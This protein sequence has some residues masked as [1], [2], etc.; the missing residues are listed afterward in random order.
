MTSLFMSLA[1]EER[2]IL[3]RIV[4]QSEND[5]TNPEFPPEAPKFPATP[6]R[7]IVIPDFSKVILKDESFNPTGTH[8]DRMAW[9]IVVTYRDILLAKERGSF[10]GPL[11]QMSLISSGS[12]AVAVQTMLKKYELPA[13]KVL[14]DSK[15]PHEKKKQLEK[16]GCEVYQADLSRS[17][18][19]TRDILALTNNQNGLD[20]TSNETL[21]PS[22]RFYDWLSYEILNQGADYCF[23]PFGSGNLYENILNVIKKEVTADTKDPRLFIDP[24]QLRRCNVMGA[25]TNDPCSKIAEKLYSPHLPFV[26]FDEQWIGF[27]KLAGYCGS[28]SNVYL[29]QEKF[30]DEAIALAKEQEVEAEYSALA[31]LALFL[32]MKD[33]VEPKSTIL[34][35]STGKTKV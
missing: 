16:I 15:T 24:E 25:T 22:T 11:P 4:V 18:L 9:E 26:H 28:R 14:V 6:T 7:E 32:Q 34:V 13:L 8:K 20:I 35:V 2:A 21:G 5:P 30:V 19:G 31:G 33:T 17:P 12:A 1:K 29:V 27:Y 23:V 10:L 3:E